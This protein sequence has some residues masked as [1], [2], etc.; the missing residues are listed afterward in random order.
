MRTPL[1]GSIGMLELALS[2]REIG[3]IR[4]YVWHGPLTDH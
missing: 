1:N 3:E 2:S 4:R